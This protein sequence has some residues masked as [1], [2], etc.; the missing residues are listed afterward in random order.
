MWGRISSIEGGG[1]TIPLY[2]TQIENS[3]PVPITS[4]IQK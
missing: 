3:K 1:F 4:T 2:F